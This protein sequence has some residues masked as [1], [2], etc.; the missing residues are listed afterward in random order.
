MKIGIITATRAEYGLLHPLIKKLSSDNNIHTEL[1][2]T[3]THLLDKYGD[4]IKKIESDQLYIHHKIPIMEEDELS[5]S[6]IIANAITQFNMLY[7]QEKYD[8]IIVLGDRYELL[9]IC[10]PALLQRIPIVHIHGGEKTEGAVDEKIRHAIT[11]LS[12]IHFATLSENSKRIV[13]MGENPKYVFSVGALGIDNIKNLHLL[14]KGELAE[15]LQINLESEDFAVVTFHPV[16][17]EDEESAENQVKELFNALIEK[18]L[19]Y[20]V[21]MPNSDTGGNLVYK[22][23]L[24]YVNHYPNKFIFRKNLGQSNYLSALKYAKLVIGNS[25]SGIIEAASFSTPAV[26]IGD[27]QKG[28]FSPANVIHCDCKKEEIL[29]S[30][31]KGMSSQFLLSLRDYVNPYGDGTTSEK[32]LAILKKIDFTSAD[33]LKKQFY[34]V[35]FEV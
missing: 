30:I 11:K 13:Q 22:Q 8:A 18:S 1:I 24:K 32:I 9:G 35:P 2:V 3:G 6:L 12:S 27:R 5:N 33:L 26:N 10:I 25:S 21:T 7:M 31:E 16:T 19:L 34:D 23:I 14:D 29:D 17:M 28:R 4:T 15:A 20:I